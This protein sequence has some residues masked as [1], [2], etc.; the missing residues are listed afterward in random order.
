MRSILMAGMLA[1]VGVLGVAAP[2]GA[3]PA[4]PVIDGH[5]RIVSTDC[6]FAAG[7]CTA[8]FDIEDVAARLSAVG[9][10]YFHGH[11]WGIRINFG[12]TWPP[13][14]SEDS[15]YCTG[16]TRDGGQTIRG[17]MTDGIGGSGTFVLRRVGS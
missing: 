14:V 15:W 8:T 9:D 6:Y 7:S 10:R 3:S 5:Y 13:G 17:T 11:V 2:A 4:I 16:L 12:E 1:T